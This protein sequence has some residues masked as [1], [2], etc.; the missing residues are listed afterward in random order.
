MRQL[1]QIACVVLI[2]FGSGL[3]SF[4]RFLNPWHTVM[5]PAH[6]SMLSVQSIDANDRYVAS[7]ACGVGIGFLVLGALGLMIPLL[8]KL[9]NVRVSDLNEISARLFSI[10]AIWMSI[11]LI[12]AFGIL[13]MPWAGTA[14][15][16]IT[17]VIV[18]LICGSAVVSTA[19]VFGWKPWSREAK[20]L[21]DPERAMMND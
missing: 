12:L 8:S 9:S 5:D 15:M 7:S 13:R 17:L 20:V 16:F 18:V 2:A 14:A 3:Y 1:I 11:A 21:A 10:I 19:L 4:G 6:I